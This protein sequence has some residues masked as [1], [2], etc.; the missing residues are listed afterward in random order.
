MKKRTLKEKIRLIVGLSIFGTLFWGVTWIIFDS[1]ETPFQG[2]ININD[3]FTSILMLFIFLLVLVIYLTNKEVI[4]AQYT[5]WLIEKIPDFLPFQHTLQNYLRQ[6]IKKKSKIIVL[7]R[8]LDENNHEWVINQIAAYNNIM[9]NP[10]IDLKKVDIQFL[11]VDK[12]TKD[13]NV[14]ISELNVAQYNYIILSSLSAIFRDAVMARE[15]LE[16]EQQECIKIIG[17]LSSINDELI[18]NIIDNDD[19]IIRIFPPDYD[20][21][22]TAVQ[23]MFSKI[24]NSICFNEKC[25]FHDKKNNVIIIHNGTYGR[26]V[27]NQCDYYFRNEYMHLD[28]NTFHDSSN[29]L[30]DKSIKFY[31]FDYTSKE[32]LMNDETHTENF[33]SLLKTW[34]DAKNYFYVVGYEPNISTILNRL[35]KEFEGEENLDSLLLFSG[36]LSMRSWKKKVLQTIQKLK[37][38]ST[39]ELFYLQLN[40]IQSINAMPVTDELNLNI[41]HYEPNAPNAK[42]DILQEMDKV[43]ENVESSP[44]KRISKTKV[45]LHEALSK[46]DNYINAFTTDSIEIALHAIEHEST[47]LYSKSQILRKDN[48]KINLLVNGDSINQ[49]SVQFLE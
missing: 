27:R 5:K 30:R 22:Q 23:F 45:I 1:A 25:D 48:Q 34:K 6:F 8:T 32:L 4:S 19:N 28:I 16:K 39:K 11:F 35:D 14:L 17:S 43:L 37:N 18:Q 47:L 9:N 21:A 26:A 33:K 15:S 13:I 10:H 40:R 36:T 12:Y 38:F 3:F 41:Y 46:N 2:L 49:Y 24:K 20:E 44:E 31:S 42:A 7:I 29:I